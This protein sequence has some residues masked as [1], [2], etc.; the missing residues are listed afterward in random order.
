MIIGPGIAIA[1]MFVTYK[2]ERNLKKVI[3]AFMML[4]YII[5]LA[6]I[7]MVMLSLKFLFVLHLIA[8]ALAYV[9]LVYYILRTRLLTLPLLAPLITL[10]YYLILVWLGNE[11]WS[12]SFS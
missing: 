9:S 7:G 4:W 11:D 6:L 1:L 12:L 5:T 3:S 8:L 2:V 10:G